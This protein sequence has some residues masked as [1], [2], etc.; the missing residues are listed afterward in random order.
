MS[1]ALEALSVLAFIAG[2]VFCLIGAIGVL[3][4]PDVFSR[5]HG[6]SVAE[7]LG[8][9]LILLGL[10]L[11]VGWSLA[12]AKVLAVTLLLFFTGPTATHALARAALARGVRPWIVGGEGVPSKR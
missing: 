2:G 3:R 1:T 8:A 5:M 4:F 10:A 7:T 11:E 9:G 12:L 6:A